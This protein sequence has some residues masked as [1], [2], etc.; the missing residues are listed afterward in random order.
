MDCLSSQQCLSQHRLELVAQ[1]G[2]GLHGLFVFDLFDITVAHVAN[3]TGEKAAGAA[4]RVE[5]DFSGLGVDTIH[6][7]GSDGTGRV[8]FARITRA[9]Q[10]VE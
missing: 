3:G 10:V 9:L 2:S 6:H 5:Q 7:E 8:V 4:G 1:T